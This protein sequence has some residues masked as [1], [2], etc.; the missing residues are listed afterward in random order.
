MQLSSMQ[1]YMFNKFM[2]IKYPALVFQWY[3]H[4]S[5]AKYSKR[6]GKLMEVLSQC[7]YS[8]SRGQIGCLS[9]GNSYDTVLAYQDCF[10]RYLGQ[11][12]VHVSRLQ[13]TQQC[14]YFLSDEVNQLLF[15]E[16][17]KKFLLTFSLVRHEITVFQDEFEKAIFMDFYAREL[18]D[19]AIVDETPKGSPIRRIF[20]INYLTDEITAEHNIE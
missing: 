19:I 18:K 15:W 10:R 7:E 6:N 14:I 12:R 5:L 9:N 8:V 20:S 2:G 4:Y 11:E 17:L 1:H 3:D 13:I 16:K